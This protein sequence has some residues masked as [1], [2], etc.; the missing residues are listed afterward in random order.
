VC[1]GTSSDS[2]DLL[3]ELIGSS[4][5]QSN[6]EHNAPAYFLSLSTELKIKVICYILRTNHKIT[7]LDHAIDYKAC[8]LSFIAL[9]SSKFRELAY[10]IYYGENM[11]S[12]PVTRYPGIFI[13]S[14]IRNLELQIHIEYG[15]SWKNV[16]LFQAGD[17]AALLPRYGG[18]TR[19]QMRFPL[20]LRK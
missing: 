16:M 19:W 15:L 9:V 3:P 13:G 18:S 2:S 12:V 20:A 1:V 14:W 4:S 11:S 5:T 10:K 7:P 8:E 17:I 6:H